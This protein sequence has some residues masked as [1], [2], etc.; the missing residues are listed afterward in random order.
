MLTS[1]WE[2]VKHQIPLLSD[3]L[4][5]TGGK[6]LTFRPYVSQLKK[7]LVGEGEQWCYSEIESCADN[8]KSNP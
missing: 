1:D 4:H 5:E 6:M 3:T 7:W 8:T 2:R